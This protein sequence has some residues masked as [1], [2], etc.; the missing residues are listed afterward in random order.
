[1]ARF[2]SM[3][4]GR[5]ERRGVQQDTDRGT[6]SVDGRDRGLAVVGEVGHHKLSGADTDA[7]L[8]GRLECT[9][10]VASITET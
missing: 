7:E 9:V 8:H 10:P 1:M 3:R 5:R 4:L 6:A 2:I